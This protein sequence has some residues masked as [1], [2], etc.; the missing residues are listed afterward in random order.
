MA[1]KRPEEDLHEAFYDGAPGDYFSEGISGESIR[2]LLAEETNQRARTGAV[3]TAEM[4][5]DVDVA[6]VDVA[7]VEPELSRADKIARKEAATGKK[8]KPQPTNWGKMT[9]PEKKAWLDSYFWVV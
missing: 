1:R 2:D 7:E 6:E 9:G 3:E 8:Y 4:E 5:P